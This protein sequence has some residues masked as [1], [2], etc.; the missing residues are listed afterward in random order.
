MHR[1]L[2]NKV[3]LLSSSPICDLPCPLQRH[4]N[5]W[6]MELEQC[7]DDL[8]QEVGEQCE[9]HQPPQVVHVVSAGGFVC[10]GGVGL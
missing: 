6:I 7:Q 3:L 8:A 9:G 1:S 2:Q 4:S 5:L 10:S